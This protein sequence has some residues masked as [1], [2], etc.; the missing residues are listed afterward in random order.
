M[1]GLALMGQAR[2]SWIP[3]ALMGH[4]LMCQALMDSLGPNGMGHF[5][6]GPNELCPQGPGPHEPTKREKRKCQPGTPVLHVC[7]DGYKCIYIYAS[8]WRQALEPRAAWRVGTRNDLR[9]FKFSAKI[10]IDDVEQ[11]SLVGRAFEALYMYTC[12]YIRETREP[13]QVLGF[14][15]FQTT[16]SK[17]KK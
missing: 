3:W 9:N 5:G 13:R 6:P 12:M 7:I 2:P 17:S 10:T 11:L 15:C 14:G 16:Q 4:A 1:M 8:L